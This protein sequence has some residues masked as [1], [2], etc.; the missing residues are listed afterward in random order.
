MSIAKL[1]P[2]EK[3]I[4]DTLRE[5]EKRLLS[6]TE[7]R[8]KTGLS[9]PAL[10]E[11]LKELQKKGLIQRDM[12]SRKYE[13]KTRGHKTYVEKEI[14][15][16]FAGLL[17]DRFTPN[18]I[19]VFV[20]GPESRVRRIHFLWRESYSEIEQIWESL[21][22]EIKKSAPKIKEKEKEGESHA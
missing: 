7:L 13:I 12:M 16:M 6:Y 19:S 18:S 8:E 5:S 11:Y 9:D 14:L 4:L 15:D 2:G 10:S 3:K 1:A 17:E 22:A 21:K 20:V